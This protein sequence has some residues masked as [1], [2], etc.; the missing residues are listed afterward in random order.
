MGARNKNHSVSAFSKLQRFQDAKPPG[1]GR[2]QHIAIDEVS[3]SAPTLRAFLLRA[4]VVLARQKRSALEGHQPERVCCRNS[5]AGNSCMRFPAA[6][7]LFICAD[8]T[9]AKLRFFFATDLAISVRLA[10]ASVGLVSV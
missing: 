9:C 6:G 1:S 10:S 4:R 2:K 8:F 3:R 5:S 7:W